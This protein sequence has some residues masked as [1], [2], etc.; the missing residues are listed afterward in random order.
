VGSV[1]FNVLVDFVYNILFLTVLY[2][3]CE[4][5][6]YFFVILVVVIFLLFSTLDALEQFAVFGSHHAGD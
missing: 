4:L 5:Q 1:G 3:L 2:W 6:I